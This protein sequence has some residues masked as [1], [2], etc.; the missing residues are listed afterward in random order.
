MYTAPLVPREK[1][2]L[3]LNVDI[4][5]VVIGRKKKKSQKGVHR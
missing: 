5:G 2:L 1:C 3:V 4:V